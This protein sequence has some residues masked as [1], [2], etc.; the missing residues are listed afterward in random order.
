[1]TERRDLRRRNDEIFRQCYALSSLNCHRASVF[2]PILIQNLDRQCGE[3]ILNN[4]SPELRYQD[5][6][7]QNENLDIRNHHLSENNVN[8]SSIGREENS[9][10]TETYSLTEINESRDSPPT[11][12]DCM[13]N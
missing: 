10:I 8:S 12:T 5:L 2:H 13:S 3:I 9:V 1:M 11:Y 7:I 6:H 4:H